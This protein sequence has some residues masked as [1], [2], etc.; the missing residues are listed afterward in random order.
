M[1]HKNQ[2]N[3]S[4]LCG[5]VEFQANVFYDKHVNWMPVDTSL[6]QIDG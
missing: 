6:K 2:V 1:P 4:C 3:G 5:A